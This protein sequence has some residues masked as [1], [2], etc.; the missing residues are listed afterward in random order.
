M[1]TD[2]IMNMEKT[3]DVLAKA[4]ADEQFT[5]SQSELLARLSWCLYQQ[6]N[7]LRVMEYDFVFS[8]NGCHCANGCTQC[9]GWE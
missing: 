1:F 3:S 9:L 2:A 8:N 5:Q 7:E 4:C 6:A